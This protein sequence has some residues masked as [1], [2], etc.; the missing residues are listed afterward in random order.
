MCIGQLGS[1]NGMAR[2]LVFAQ[3]VAVSNDVPEAEDSDSLQPA[4][5]RLTGLTA[6]LLMVDYPVKGSPPPALAGLSRLQRLCFLAHDGPLPLGPYSASLRL[7][8]ASAVCLNHSTALLCCAAA[9]SMLLCCARA[10]TA[11]FGSGRSS[12]PGC[13]VCKCRSARIQSWVGPPAHPGLW[14]P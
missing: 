4:L 6:L 2:S 1:L 5:Q 11:L 12:T 9:W 8:G 13:A 10:P 3:A 14:P 7:L